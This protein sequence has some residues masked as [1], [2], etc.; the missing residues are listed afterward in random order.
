LL[1]VFSPI[2]DQGNV[3]GRLP[4]G[5]VVA[6]CGGI[7]NKRIGT[8]RPQRYLMTGVEKNIA[9]L[10]CLVLIMNK[11]L[12]FSIVIG[13]IVC[14]S[15]GFLAGQAT[16]TSVNTWYASLEKPFFNPPNWIFAPVWTLLYLL[17][18]V[19]VGR[20][21]NYGI[22]HRWVKRAVYLFGFQLL[23]NGLWSLVFFGLRNPI[24][25]LV[26]IVVLL[27][28]IFRTIQQF[29]TVDLLATRL[30]YPYLIWV[31]FATFLNAAIVFLNFL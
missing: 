18:G 27:F 2:F 23:I 13:V 28:L 30:L 24:G 4:L 20:V 15:V 14:L 10:K 26:V 8:H 12:V 29:R 22:H 19:A 21:W 3:A 11:K 9:D 16:Q 1:S 6:F 5:L 31:S 7:E 25:A 17:M